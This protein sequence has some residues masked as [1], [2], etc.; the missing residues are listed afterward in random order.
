MNR[1]PDNF[2][3]IIPSIFSELWPFANFGILNLP[4]R[5]LEKIFELGALIWDDESGAKPGFL[6]RGFRSQWGFDLINLPKI[7]HGNK[8]IWTQSGVR[9]S[10]LNPL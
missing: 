8:L 1:L 5:Y 6:G 9:T 4:A 2:S 10:P 7:L 3:S